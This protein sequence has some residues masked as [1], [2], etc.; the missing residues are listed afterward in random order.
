MRLLHSWVH[1][2]EIDLLRG[3]PR[4]PVEDLAACDYC[5]MVSRWQDRPRAGLWPI[6]LRETLPAIPIPLAD[7]APDVRLD[8]QATVH[9]VYDAARYVNWIYTSEPEPRL[10]EDNLSWAHQIAKVA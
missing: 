10:S 4:M 3:G 7:P 9:R 2:V 5:V 1:L 8:L 6:Q